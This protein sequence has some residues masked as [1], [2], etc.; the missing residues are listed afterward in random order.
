[1]PRG[2]KKT[3]ASKAR[4]LA[5]A[6]KRAEAKVRAQ[7]VESDASDSNPGLCCAHCLCA[8]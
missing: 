1:M 8:H 6:A 4:A 2:N 7:D 5:L 3:N